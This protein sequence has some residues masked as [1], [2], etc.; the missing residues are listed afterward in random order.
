MFEKLTLRFKKQHFDKEKDISKTQS[1]EFDLPLVNAK[2]GGN[3]IMYFG[4]KSDFESAKMTIDIVNDGAVS[5]GNVYPQPKETGVLYNA[6]LI[7]AKFDVTERLLYF[8]S[9]A[10]KKSIK[11]KFGYENKASWS[12][13][14]YELIFLPI[15]IDND[16]DYD[17]M[18]SLIR[19]IE[20]IVI[21][22]VV[23]WTDK[24]IST[25]KKVVMRDALQT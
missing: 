17:Y 11:L 19:G 13:V 9:T 14:Q 4:R 5:T 24:K 1:E 2:D 23:K 7:T 25:T 22:D 15:T 10:I 12:K 21:K 6:Y 20:K 8:F 18:E 16:I 3:G